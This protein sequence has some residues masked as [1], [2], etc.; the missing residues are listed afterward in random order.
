MK[1]IQQVWKGGAESIPQVFGKP[2][3]EL[4][5]EWLATLNQPVTPVKTL[6]YRN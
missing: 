5:Q 4:E 2:L 1:Q 3:A 6:I